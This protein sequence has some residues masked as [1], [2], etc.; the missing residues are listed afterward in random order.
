MDF[1]KT[2]NPIHWDTSKS[3]VSSLYTLSEKSLSTAIIFAII[4][5]FALYSELKHTIILWTTFVIFISLIRLY[6]AN[7]YKKEP[8]RYSLKAWYQR[9][10]ILAFST[11][12]LVSFLGFGIIPYL[13]S[14]YQLF[15]LSSLVGLTAG[16]TISLSSDFRIATIYISIIILPLVISTVLQETPLRFPLSIMLIL[17]YFS[18][19]IMILKN[20][21]QEEQIKNLMENNQNLLE[22]NKRFIAD[23][24]HQ[25]RTPLTVIMTNTSLLEMKHK[26]HDSTHINQ[27]NSAINIL[28]NSYEDLSYI[29]S[30]NTLSYMPIQINLTNFIEERIN[31][32][33]VIAQVNQ[34]TFIPD[35]NQNIWITMNDTELERVVDNNL[36]NAIK[37][38]SENSDIKVILKKNHSG[39]VLQF[40]SEGKPIRNIDMI[41]DKNYTENH[42]AKRSLG[43]GLHMVKNICEKNDITYTVNSNANINTFTYVFKDIEI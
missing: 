18:Q 25:I 1:K 24:V 19:I 35:I 14:Y 38:G 7:L 8:L 4:V 29:I 37:H 3:I 33:E 22:E 10:I 12:L 30:N 41:F 15:V 13:D 39:I 20:Y 21:A 40:I 26:L 6:Y 23:M 31:F 36:S 2:L 42:H 17:F 28:S 32:F 11:G 34:K 27:I 5:S 9:F 16:A 43:L